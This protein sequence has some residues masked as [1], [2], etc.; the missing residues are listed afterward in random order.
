LLKSVGGGLKIN[1]WF[2][3]G[4]WLAVELAPATDCSPKSIGHVSIMELYDVDFCSGF[5]ERKE[6]SFLILP[7]RFS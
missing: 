7:W 4:D 6:P 2:S 1:D 3:S 5:F